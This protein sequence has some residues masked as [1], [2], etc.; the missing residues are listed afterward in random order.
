M[1]YNIGSKIKGLAKAIFII[2]TISAIIAGGIFIF[3]EGEPII[4]LI[5][6][7]AGPFAAWISTLLIYGFGEL[8][9]KTSEI[10]R[11]TANSAKA[12]ENDTKRINTMKELYAKGLISD[13]EYQQVIS[14][15][16]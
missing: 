7:I 15:V 13:E 14:K 12:I 4:G 10:A 3:N 9:D 11:N 2:E 1:Y 16:Q 8:I 6:I 5:I